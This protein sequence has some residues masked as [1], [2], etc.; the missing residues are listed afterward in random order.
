MKYLI[1]LFTC[2]AAALTIAM[3]HYNTMPLKIA[4]IINAAVLLGLIFKEVSTWGAFSLSFPV[5]AIY[6]IILLK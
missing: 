6:G 4:N 3:N 5:V 2:S 1:S